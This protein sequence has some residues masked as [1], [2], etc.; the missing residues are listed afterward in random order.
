MCVC[1]CFPTEVYH[2][3]S[4]FDMEQGILSGSLQVL[5]FDAGGSLEVVNVIVTGRRTSLFLYDDNT[6]MGMER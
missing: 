4:V 2:S 1:V 5:P 6:D 3:F